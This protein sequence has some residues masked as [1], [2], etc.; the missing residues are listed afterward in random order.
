MHDQGMV[1]GGLKGV[2]FRT[3]VTLPHP[4]LPDPKA[5]ILI[6]N[7][8]RACLAGPGLLTMTSDQLSFFAACTEGGAIRW[9]SPELL[10]PNKSGLSGSRL[11]KESDC[12]ALGMVIY[13]VLSG[14][15]PFAEYWEHQVADMVRGGK[16]PSRPQGKGGTWFT[17]DIWGILELCWKAHPRDRISAKAVLL[18][19]KGIESPSDPS[20]FSPFHPRLVFNYPCAL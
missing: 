8:D 13:E 2:R 12:Y 16:R 5:N 17:D 10:N 19:L 9:T 20:A 6:D 15:E 3:S 4:R 11:T 14:Q 7:D 18:C 1:H